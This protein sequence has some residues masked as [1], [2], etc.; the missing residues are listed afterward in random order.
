VHQI[1]LVDDEITLQTTLADT[2]EDE[3]CR[4]LVAGT[5]SEANHTLEANAFDLVLCDL[6]LPDGNGIDVLRR[7]REVQPEVPVV[8][9][10]AFGTVESAV[11]A[12]KAG[13]AEYITKPFEETQLLAVV[14]RHCELR[15]LRRRVRELESLRQRP[16]GVAPAFLKALELAE[17]VAPTD[18]TILLL[19]ETGTGKEDLA[20]HIHTCSKRSSGPFMAVNCAALPETL[21]EAE[22]FGHERGAF[23]GAVRARRGRFEAADGGTLFLDEVAEMSPAVQA[24]LLRVLQERTFERL[25]SNQ[26]VT[27]NVRLLA[28]TRRD[29][30]AEAQAGSFR[31]DL[32]YRL[33]VVPISV[34][35]LRER[36]G[37]VPLLAQH[38]VRRYAAEGGRELELAPETLRCLETQEF[39]GNVRELENLIQRLVVTCPRDTV[40][41]EDLPEE[42]RARRE[43]RV[44]VDPMQFT[45]TL[46]EQLAQL[47]EMVLREAL[48][49]FDG[50][51]GRMAAAL[52]IS[53]KIL[54]EKLKIHG[55]GTGS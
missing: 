41:M 8:I 6:K 32:Y 51:R 27:T 21:L 46:A 30:A 18:T 37:D 3:G 48:R 28:A 10:T 34:P 2:L 25:G 49:R 24:K 11:E 7:V 14:E 26:V 35:P 22:L 44:D 36:P 17:T 39:P 45:G 38:F 52:G 31:D 13:A 42:Y 53:R 20:R 50:H 1:L 15:Q 43:L 5:V 23:T 55:L 16:L 33:R 40:H 29:L 47:E 9:L 4:V 54:W 19:G 12:M